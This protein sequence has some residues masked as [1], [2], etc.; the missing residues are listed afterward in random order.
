ME[1]SLTLLELNRLLIEGSI[2]ESIYCNMHSLVVNISVVHNLR[3]M[4]VCDTFSLK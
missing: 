2:Q 1:E 3:C 4:V